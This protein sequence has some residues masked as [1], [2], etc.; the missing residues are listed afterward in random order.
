MASCADRLFP[1]FFILMPCIGKD[2][3]A[4]LFE[5]GDEIFQLV[6]VIIEVDDSDIGIRNGVRGRL[7]D[8]CVS[9]C[10]E[11]SPEAYGPEQVFIEEQ[12]GHCLVL[13]GWSEKIFEGFGC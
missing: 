3:G 7:G 4:L 9:L 2:K 8:D 10:G 11:G 6:E 1:E 5:L 13:F 12:D